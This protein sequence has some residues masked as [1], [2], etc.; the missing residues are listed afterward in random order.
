MG[1]SHVTHLTLFHAA[2]LHLYLLRLA[3][4]LPV[5]CVARFRGLAFPVGVGPARGRYARAAVAARES[6]DHS[7]YATMARIRKDRVRTRMLG[8]AIT[9]TLLLV[10]TVAVY[11]TWRPGA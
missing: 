10:L 4:C 5:R 11:A 9:G 6:H 3:V 2:R 8:T 1:R 7:K